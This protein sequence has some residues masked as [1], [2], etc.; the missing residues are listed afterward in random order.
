VEIVRS[1]RAEHHVSTLLDEP[2]R[3]AATDAAAR[4]RDERHLALEA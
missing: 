4:P 3:D 1:A 2:Q